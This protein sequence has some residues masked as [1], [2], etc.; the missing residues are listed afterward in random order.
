[1]PQGWQAW[2]VQMPRCPSGK[3]SSVLTETPPLHPAESTVS[4]GSPWNKP[5]PVCVC[6]THEVPQT[7]PQ[8]PAQLPQATWA[9]CPFLGQD[10]GPQR[11]HSWS[12]GCKTGNQGCTRDPPGER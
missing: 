2:P 10:P 3:E 9:D 12:V 6:S 1:M 7:R 4:H 8:R 11:G 5:C